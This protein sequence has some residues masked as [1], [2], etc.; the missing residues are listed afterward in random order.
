MI[1]SNLVALRMVHRRNETCVLLLFL[2]LL[3]LFPQSLSSQNLNEYE[4]LFTSRAPLGLRLSESLSVLGF[5]GDNSAA[6][7]SGKIEV[8]DILRSVN[9][10]DLTKLDFNRAAKV[11]REAKVP[12]KYRFS[13]FSSKITSSVSEDSKVSLQLG[14]RARLKVNLNAAFAEFGP[15]SVCKFRSVVIASPDDGC[16]LFSNANDLKN[17]LVIVRRG[18]CEFTTKLRM[19]QS[20]GGA[21][22]V[23]VN[24]GPSLF[25]MP[26]GDTD[27]SDLYA[28]AVLINSASGN[29]LFRYIES[30]PGIFSRLYSAEKC[31]ESRNFTL[32]LSS[33]LKPSKNLFGFVFFAQVFSCRI[34][35]PNQ[36]QA[37]RLVCKERRRLSLRPP[38]KTK[39]KPGF[40]ALFLPSLLMKCPEWHPGLAIPSQRVTGPLL[41]G[42]GALRGPA[43]SFSVFR[44]EGRRLMLAHC[45]LSDGQYLPARAPLSLPLSL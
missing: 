37:W 15:Q 2:G 5:A 6:E 8:G 4:V 20:V 38:R 9:G 44:S 10:V 12:K 45:S 17:K 43:S 28:P 23:V 13:S 33:H 22:I 31:K 42:L 32:A 35:S 34:V 21:G 30:Q 18:N 24:D 36:S 40:S 29:T 41:E 1:F 16:S 3:E 26:A 39:S 11:I 27:T 19:V 14:T 25:Q 7:K